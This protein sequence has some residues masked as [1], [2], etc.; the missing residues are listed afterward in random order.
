MGKGWHVCLSQPSRNCLFQTPQPSPSPSLSLFL[1]TTCLEPVRNET[2]HTNHTHHTVNVSRGQV[3]KA[4]RL[5]EVCVAGCN[6]WQAGG[7]LQNPLQQPHQPPA[8]Q[9]TN[10]SCPQHNLPLEGGRGQVGECRWVGPKCSCPAWGSRINLSLPSSL[11]SQMSHTHKQKSTPSSQSTTTTN[12]PVWGGEGQ[13]GV[14][15]VGVGGRQCAAGV[16][17]EGW[18]GKGVGVGMVSLSC[19]VLNEPEPV[20]AQVKCSKGGE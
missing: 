13:V 6:V 1:S 4:G 2:N 15:E 18:G 12:V 8:H 16:V 19:P 5:V 20:P 11:L 17:G 9:P 3:G 14:G 7:V 10:L